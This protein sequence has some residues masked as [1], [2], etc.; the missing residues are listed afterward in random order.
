L[1][2]ELLSYDDDQAALRLNSIPGIAFGRY[3]DA[4]RSVY[5]LSEACLALTDYPAQELLS[6][7][8][9]ALTF[10]DLI[11]PEDLVDL[12][13]HID[14]ALEARQPYG[15]E[16]RVKTKAGAQRWFLE[17]GYFSAADSIEGLITDISALKQTQVQL[18]RD[19]FYDKLTG[20]PNRLLF[21][22][23]LAQAVR[24]LQR[25]ADYQFAVLFLDLDRFKVINDSLGHR[26]GDL[27]LTQV[28]TRLEACVRPGDTVA[29]I[30]GDEFTMLID[31]V[32]GVQD[33]IQVAERILNDMGALFQVDGHEIC[34][35]TSIGIAMSAP[36]YVDAE[37]LIRD[38]DIALYQAKALGKA[39]YAIFQPGMH[40][41]A[42]AR[43]QLEN[44]LRRALANQ[45]FCLLYQP[46]VNLESGEVAG[47]ESF[48]YWYHPTRGLLPPGEFLPV[49][50]EA[51]LMIAIGHWVLA[52][53]CAQM[54]LWH[55]RFAQ[56][57]SVFITVNLSSPELAHAELVPV[58]QAVLARSG[59]N[60]RAL[61]IEITEELL[62]HHSEAVLA[63]L[64]QV[65]AL[66][67]QL[68]IDDFGTGYSSLSYLDRLPVDLLKIDRSFVARV[69][70]PDN[71][72][73]VR[74]ILTLAHN[75][76]LDGVAEGV[77]STA[78]V[79]QLRALR[80]QYGQGFL[81]ARP[82]EALQAFRFLEQQFAGDDFT[83][84]SVTALP[85]LL[86][87][88]P[89]GHYQMLLV[90]RMSWSVGR[91][92]DCSIFLPDRRVS[93][94]HAMILQLA[95][96]N[97]F[98]WVD[99]GSRNGSFINFQPVKQPMR[100]KD[101]DLIRVGSRL[102]MQFIAAPASPR[103]ARGSLS[104]LMHQMSL[105]HGQ[106]WR[107]VLMAHQVSIIWQAN[108]IPI[109]HTLRQLEAAGEP[110]PK[111][112]LVDI[113]SFH[114]DFSAFFEALDAAFAP[115]PVILTM[116][117][118]SIRFDELRSEAIQAGAVDLI[119]AFRFV[120]SDF[121]EY[122]ADLA[123]KAALVL[124]TLG[125]HLHDDEQLRNAAA[126]ALRSVLKNETLF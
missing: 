85:R 25:D 82:M 70:S 35:T 15:V 42:V 7:S 125:S 106:L 119:P 44:D 9:D 122:Q 116:A 101:G 120:G 64:R 22:D 75:L 114:S 115:I 77:E 110:L 8:E 45:E 13:A 99:L 16:Y 103:V 90:G 55:R 72:E 29:R 18:Q 17:Q 48:V 38:A 84:L 107:E 54:A 4:D 109:L 113:Q 66:G 37:N 6:Q 61:K 19:A 88:T 3:L 11:Y 20:L 92:Q 81:F 68:C 32:H 23:R 108:D 24:R 59:L 10:N 118:D 12:L 33:V 105:L 34:S 83:A 58:L 71:L 104:L 94:E 89:T 78:Q 5:F 65:R 93:R 49:A 80:C 117:D 26:A 112:L 30:G 100:L 36:G 60:P 91:A 102:E 123:R 121:L 95:L 97:E 47:F 56:A 46:I 126:N 53:A 43:L 31:A 98:F 76:G 73:I 62:V 52:T 2:R 63:Q 21:L 86:I 87:H 57:R 27:L 111:L 40:I 67:I 14:G 74:T 28:A 69:D 39:C 96:S 79:A 41:Y 51:G 1:T 50:Q 124:N